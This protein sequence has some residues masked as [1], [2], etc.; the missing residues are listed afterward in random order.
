[1]L[2]RYRK[3]K[4]KRTDKSHP[5]FTL[6]GILTRCKVVDVYDGDTITINFYLQKKIVKMSCRLLGIDTPELRT[7]DIKEKEAGKLAKE[8]LIN[9]CKPDSNLLYVKFGK[10][11]KYGRPL[12]T[13]YNK[14]HIRCKDIEYKNSINNRMVMMGFALTYDGKGKD[15]FDFDNY[16]IKLLI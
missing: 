5:R 13:L 6:D 11:D 4:L 9:L 8:I 16:P 12:V 1:M 14:N 10:M 15:R 2:S 3:Y 7:L